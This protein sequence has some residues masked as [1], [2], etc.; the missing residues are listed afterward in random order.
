MKIKDFKQEG[1]YATFVL[2]GDVKVANA[3]RRYLIGGVPVYAIDKVIFYEN[4]SSFFNEYIAHRLG[5]I[6]IKVKKDVEDGRVMLDEKGPK[7]IYSGDLMPNS[8]DIEIPIKNIPI[9]ELL[10]GQTLRLEGVLK[11]DRGLHHAKFQSGIASYRQLD[12][13]TFEFFVETL[14]HFEP[15]ELV[16]KAKAQIRE[17]LKKM[18][19]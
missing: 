2:E 7:K 12:D 4:E 18:L 6:P 10:E 3:L 14:Y 11:K 5:M 9:I 17:D 1:N 13:N 19:P 15:K 16:E 8:K